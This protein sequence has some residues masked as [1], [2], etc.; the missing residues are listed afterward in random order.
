MFGGAAWV[1]FAKDKHA[2][3]EV[4]NDCEFIRNLY[5]DYNIE[6]NNSLL[7][8]YNNVDKNYNELIIKS[9]PGRNPWGFI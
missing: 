2:D 9:T 5:R 4:Y 1:L 7:N 8:R 6:R 3:M